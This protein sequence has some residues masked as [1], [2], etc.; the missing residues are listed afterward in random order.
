MSLTPPRA[1]IP[2]DL[3]REGPHYV[4]AV[5][6]TG[7]TQSVLAA[8]DIYASNGMKLLSK[9]T[10]I[11]SHQFEQLTQHRLAVPLDHSLVAEKP[12]NAALLALEAG[13]IIEHHGVYRRM[14]MRTGDPLAVK[15]CLSDLKLPTPIQTRL[16]VMRERRTVIFEHSL[17]TAM[18]AFMLAQRMGLPQHERSAVALA[19]LCHDFGE[20]HTDPAMLAIGHHIIPAERRFVHVH[21]IT[22]YVLVHELPGFPAAAAQAVLHHH[23]RLDGS[24]YPNDLPG[25]KIPLLARVLAVA[26]VAEAVIKR[27]DLPRLDMLFRLNQVR[28]DARAVGALRDLIHIG[29]ED[30]TDTPNE[31]GAAHQLAHLADLLQAWFTLR[32][33]LEKQFSPNPPDASPLAFLFERMTAIRQLVL[34]AGFDPD[35][36][37]SMLAIA[38]EDPAILLELRGMLDEMEW[39]L[40]DLANEIDRRSPE[41]EGMSQGALKGLLGRLRTA[42][43]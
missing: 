9:G 40:E 39:L 31:H 18:I 29:P 43:A 26:D 20:M 7:D 15:A 8:E 37:A 30:A 1:Q 25:E 4:R 10:R 41:L 28:F 16:T 36:M 19:G 38:R 34:Q 33:M 3:P 13:K 35:N 6:E 21:P 22:S 32:G 12:V 14:A 27:F 24:G 5:A 11:D 2:D 17:R 23:E 42:P